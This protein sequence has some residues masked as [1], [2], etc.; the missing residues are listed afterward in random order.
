MR[1][2]LSMV[3]RFVRCSPTLDGGT[4]THLPSHLGFHPQLGRP[5][6][7]AEGRV[8]KQR[9]L[10]EGKAI[11]APLVTC[12]GYRKQWDVQQS[13]HSPPPQDFS[14]PGADLVDGQWL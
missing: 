6:R 10:Q 8:P 11:T 9:S 5:F 4:V 13:C 7:K 14:G 1:M 3:E 12:G 2:Y